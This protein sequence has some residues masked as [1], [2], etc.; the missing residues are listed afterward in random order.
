MRKL[1]ARMLRAVRTPPGAVS[2]SYTSLK[3][4]SESRILALRVKIISEKPRFHYANRII[5]IETKYPIV[6]NVAFH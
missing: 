2:T 1:V 5:Y 4:A 6:L 3:P